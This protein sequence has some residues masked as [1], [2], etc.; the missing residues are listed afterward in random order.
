MTPEKN[1]LLHSALLTVIG[2]GLDGD[3]TLVSSEGVVEHVDLAVHRCADD[4]IVLHCAV[5]GHQQV[6][7]AVLHGRLDP[8]RA[9]KESF[10]W[11]T[12]G[13]QLHLVALRRGLTRW[14]REAPVSRFYSLA[15]RPRRICIRTCSR[16]DPDLSKSRV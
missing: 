14:S 16:P 6:T 10:N 13:A 1:K 12:G 15:G 11:T 2:P 4:H 8:R 5:T 9:A 7:G 3:G